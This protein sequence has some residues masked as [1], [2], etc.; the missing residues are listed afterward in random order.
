M[1]RNARRKR[2]EEKK[3]SKE[4]RRERTRTRTRWQRRCCRCGERVLDLQSHKTQAACLRVDL[5]A[6]GWRW[7]PGMKVLSSWQ[8]GTNI[9]LHRLIEGTEESLSVWKTSSGAHTCPGQ[10][11]E[12]SSLIGRM[13][14]LR[15]ITCYH[16]ASIGYQAL[17]CRKPENIQKNIHRNKA[18]RRINNS[19]HLL[20]LVPYPYP[21]P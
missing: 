18:I 10:C 1:V 4:G 17:C 13:I 21:T 20:S 2:K 8:R 12:I 5:Q 7:R 9:H 16:I 19:K 15:N 11:W 3:T 14:L 6:D